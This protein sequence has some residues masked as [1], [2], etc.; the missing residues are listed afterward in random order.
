MEKIT[1]GVIE[2]LIRYELERGEKELIELFRAV[3]MGKMSQEEFKNKSKELQ[4]Y[5]VWWGSESSHS[6][7]KVEVNYVKK[8][9]EDFYEISVTCEMHY[10]SG[11]VYWDEN[12][13]VPEYADK[14]KKAVIKMIVNEALEVKE[15]DFQWI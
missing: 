10:E 12:G 15:F 13:T 1:E 2:K 9:E 3:D 4:G 6:L 7:G 8:L 5:G 11:H 14:P